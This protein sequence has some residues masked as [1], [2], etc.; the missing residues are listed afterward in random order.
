MA[1]TSETWAVVR[2]HGGTAGVDAVKGQSHVSLMSVCFAVYE[3]QL[4]PV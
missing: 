4:R 2:Q 3:T 1:E